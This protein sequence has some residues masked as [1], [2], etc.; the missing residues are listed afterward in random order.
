MTASELSRKLG[1][2]VTTVSEHLDVLK[3]SELVE[4]VE[5]PGKKWIYYRLT[6]PGQRIV[7][8]TSYRFVF[9]FVVALFALVG[10]LYLSSVDAYPGHWLYGLDRNLENLQLLL[11]PSNLGRAEL[12]IQHAEERLEETKNVIEEGEHNLEW[13]A[14]NHT[15]NRSE[16]DGPFNFKVDKTVP[17]VSITYEVIGGNM[18]TGWIFEFAATA[19]DFESGMDRVEFYLS[20]VV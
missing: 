8:P 1:K 10:G 13:F 16:I 17:E 15:G 5:R 4:R 12:H 11:T 2:H 6:K 7:H 20:Y 18:Y 14:V 19:T 9:V 3:K